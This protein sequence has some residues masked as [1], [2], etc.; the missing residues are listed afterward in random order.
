MVQIIKKKSGNCGCMNCN[1][2]QDGY[3][4][5]P[6]SVYHKAENEKRGHYEPVCSIECGKELAKNYQ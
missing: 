5:H 1:K 2:V 6:Y 3:K 4:Y